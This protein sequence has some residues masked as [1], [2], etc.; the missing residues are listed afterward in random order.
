MVEP[1]FTPEEI[2][3]EEWRPIPDAAGYYEASS[4]GRVRRT[5]SITRTKAGLILAPSMSKGYLQLTLWR[6]GR[7]LC[8][9]VHLFVAAAFIGPCPSGHETNHK[10]GKKLNNRADNLEY[11]SKADHHD[12]T[13]NVLGQDSVGSRNANARISE[14][15]IPA[16]RLRLAAGE[17]LRVIAADYDVTPQAI[18]RIK[19]RVT[20]A[21]VA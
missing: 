6:G 13:R 4:L 9:S 15:D 3:S 19:K 5:K 2:E 18:W 1:Q 16:I 8:R 12:H 10:D 17:F 14:D 7:K 20:W 21:H 11:L